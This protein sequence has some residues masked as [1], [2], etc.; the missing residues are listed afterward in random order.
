MAFFSKCFFFSLIQVIAYG[1]KEYR[2]S[3]RE[4]MNFVKARRSVVQPNAGFWK[5]L[6]TYEGIL[7]SR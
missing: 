5:Q 1:M 6:T 4:T 3:L 7:N 2:W